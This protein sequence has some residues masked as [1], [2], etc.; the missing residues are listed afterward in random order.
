LSYRL[1]NDYVGFVSDE[2]RLRERRARY[3]QLIGPVRNAGGVR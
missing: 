2:A 1:A 3:E